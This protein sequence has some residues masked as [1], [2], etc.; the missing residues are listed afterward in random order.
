M[1]ALSGWMDKAHNAFSGIKNAYATGGQQSSGLGNELRVKGEMM[2]TGE[3]ALHP[4][5][6]PPPGAAPPKFDS[7]MDYVGGGGA[8]PGEKRI[9]VGGMMKP[10]G[11]GGGLTGIKKITQ[12]GSQVG[13]MVQKKF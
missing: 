12:P 9:D 1:S 7:P 5:S 10:L 3:T 11:G 2:K 6:S 8:R 4:G 13:S